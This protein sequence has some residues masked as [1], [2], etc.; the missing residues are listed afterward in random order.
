M[1]GPSDIV[2]DYRPIDCSLHDRYEAAAVR[3]TPV[4]IEWVDPVAGDRIA[5]GLIVDV[6]ARS[7]A[8]FLVMD[9]GSE[10]RLDYIS[11]SSLQ[12]DHAG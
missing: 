7:G 1:A 10:I 8:E 4:R 12:S 9:D 3:R 6:L 11:S 5:E 2:T